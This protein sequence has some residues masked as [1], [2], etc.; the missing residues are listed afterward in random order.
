[1]ER[2]EFEALRDLPGKV[3]RGDVRLAPLQRDGLHLASQDVRIEAESAVPLRLTVIYLPLVASLRINV[4][5]PG[6]GPIC[7]LEV[8]STDHPGAGRS[9]KHALD[10]ATCPRNNLKRNVT[11]RPALEGQ[12][13]LAVWQ[14]FCQDASIEHDGRLLCEGLDPATTVLTR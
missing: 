4:D 7:R 3:I 6:V 5:V 8:N 2:V 12:T 9:H 1:M 11:P 10:S 14:R 13:M